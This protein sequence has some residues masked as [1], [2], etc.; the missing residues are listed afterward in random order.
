[1]M[2]GVLQKTLREMTER[3]K[4][5]ICDE[6]RITEDDLMNSTEE[7]LDAIYDGLCE[8]EIEETVPGELTDRGKIA[9]DLVTLMGLAIAK[10]EGYL[11]EDDD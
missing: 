6:F 4:K 8:I 5:F 1:M 3:Q 11:D 9:E 7:E 2:A 10:D